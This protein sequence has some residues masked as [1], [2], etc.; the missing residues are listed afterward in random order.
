MSQTEK[1]K[2]GFRDKIKKMLE[3][4]SPRD[5]KKSIIEETSVKFSL[6]GGNVHSELIIAE[7][8]MDSKSKLSF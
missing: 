7:A 5:K 2:L 6:S 8:I 3:S 4:D 1:K